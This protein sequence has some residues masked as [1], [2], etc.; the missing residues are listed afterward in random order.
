MV[1]EVVIHL[2]GGVAVGLIRGRTVE[3]C[4]KLGTACGAAQT[5]TVLPGYIN[6][7]DVYDIFPKVLIKDLTGRFIR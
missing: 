3:D 1:T 2:W 7:D 6:K 4:I 5:K